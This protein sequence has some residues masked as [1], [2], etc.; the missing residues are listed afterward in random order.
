VLLKLPLPTVGKSTCTLYQ[1]DTKVVNMQIDTELISC[2]NV[3]IHSAIEILFQFIFLFYFLNLD[4]G[5]LY[6]VEMCLFQFEISIPEHNLLR[7]G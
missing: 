3:M 1:V 5:S 2:K 4:Q 7:A 6:C